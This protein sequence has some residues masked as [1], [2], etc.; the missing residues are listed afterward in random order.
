M[1]N[2]DFTRG[3]RKT[4]ELSCLLHMVQKKPILKEK[5]PMET[6]FCDFLHLIDQCFFQIVSFVV[7]RNTFGWVRS[8]YSSFFAWF[9]RISLELFLAQ[10]HIWLA[11]DA[12]GRFFQN[13]FLSIIS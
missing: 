3:K 10:Y 12:D 7:M 13:S 1:N 11:A 4:A 2:Y 6:V 8:R 9:G 5:I